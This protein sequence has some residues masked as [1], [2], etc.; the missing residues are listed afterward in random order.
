MNTLEKV[1]YLLESNKNTYI[2]G[3]AMADQCGVSRNAIWKSI[4]ELRQRG[5][6]IEAVSNKGYKL[7]E[8]S[9]IISAEGIRAEL[10]GTECGLAEMY[11]YEMLEST[12]DEA[13]K[14]AIKGA[15]HGTVV[16]A[17]SQ[18]GGRGRKDH[19]FYSPEGGLYMSV[20]LR[21][22]RLSSID[23]REITAFV[24]KSVSDSIKELTGIDTYIEGINDLYADG[25]KLCGI[26][27]ESGSEFDSGTLQWIVAG[28]GINFD[29]DVDAFPEEVKNRAGSLYKPGEATTT[30]NKL[31]ARILGKILL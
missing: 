31:I 29:S 23:S 1:L 14:L 16:I 7:A 17:A 21:P 24:G 8:N 27:I 30:K 9:D 18:S 3:E 10:T 22:E 11:V 26:L 13:K 12:N 2:S 25:K 20:I 6:G 15:A 28:I 19:T 4:K 5:Y